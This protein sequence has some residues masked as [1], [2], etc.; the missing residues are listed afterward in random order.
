MELSITRALNE[1]KLLDAR[2]RREILEGNFIGVQIGKKPIN[3]Y[4]T[5][6]DFTKRIQ[7]SMDAVK[8]LT[9][10]R[11]EIKSAIVES[12]A[13]T[14]VSVAGRVYSV[15]AAIERK[16]SIEYDRLLLNQLRHQL[17]GSLQTIASENQRAKDRLDKQ[18]DQMLGQDRKDK[19]AEIDVFTKAFNETNEAKKI[20]PLELQKVIDDLQRSIEDWDNEIDFILSESNVRTMIEVSDS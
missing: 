8:A 12:N 1:I 11:N 13:R 7:A 14:S 3:N 16:T 10:R 20:D 19:Q 18:I 9:K 5:P 17:I 2:I 4:Y 15:A 6:E